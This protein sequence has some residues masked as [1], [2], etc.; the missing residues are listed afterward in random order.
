MAR[1]TTKASRKASASTKPLP[2][3]RQQGAAVSPSARPPSPPPSLVTL[4]GALRTLEIVMQEIKVPRTQTE[5]EQMEGWLARAKKYT[6]EVRQELAP[7]LALP[8]EPVEGTPAGTAE[9]LLLVARN[10]IS[11][12]AWLIGSQ[13]VPPRMIALSTH[14]QHVHT[15]LC[16]GHERGATLAA[17]PRGELIARLDTR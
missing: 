13:D 10:R 15:V 1:P 14:L 17:G 2:R 7:L 8:G 12:L 5:A 9:R 4:D 16:R 6:A 11:E 3:G